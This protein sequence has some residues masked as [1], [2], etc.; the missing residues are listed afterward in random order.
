MMN[1]YYVY[2]EVIDFV[3]EFHLVQSHHYQVHTENNDDQQV[4]YDLK[5]HIEQKNE[6]LSTIPTIHYAKNKHFIF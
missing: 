1:D 6:V 2:D 5:H 3:E 4:L